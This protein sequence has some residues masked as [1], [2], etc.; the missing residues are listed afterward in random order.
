MQINF[1]Q[2]QFP[3]RSCHS[4]AWIST[5]HRAQFSQNS[6]SIVNIS[7]F[8][9]SA[10][11]VN[12]INIWSGKPLG[13]FRTIIIIFYFRT[14]IYWTT[15]TKYLSWLT[16][17]IFLKPTFKSQTSKS[18]TRINF[19]LAANRGPPQGTYTHFPPGKTFLYI[20]KTRPQNRIV[21]VFILGVAICTVFICYSGELIPIFVTA[22]FRTF[23]LPIIKSLEDSHWDSR[24]GSW[25][26]LVSTLSF[27]FFVF[28][29]I[30]TL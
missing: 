18:Q 12:H 8:K 4:W 7:E 27:L 13:V 20:M 30:I 21:S 10:V 24:V 9:V 22:E 14:I 2:F 17:F 11:L 16:V 15:K 3:R 23:D 29:F 1:P 19:R 6:L 26:F 25:E 28:N 5:K